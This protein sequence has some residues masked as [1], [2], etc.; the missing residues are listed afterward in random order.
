MKMLERLRALAK[1]VK[2][3]PCEAVSAQW[4]DCGDAQYTLEFRGIKAVGEDE[5]KTLQD[6]VNAVPKLLAVVE[7][8]SD[9]AQAVREW[10]MDINNTTINDC[11]VLAISYQQALAALEVEA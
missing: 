11:D 5:A 6:A 3:C 9:L 4:G 2:F 8:G 10:A 1:A 7:L